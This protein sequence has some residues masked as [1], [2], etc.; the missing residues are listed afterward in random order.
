LQTVKEPAAAPRLRE[1]A[2]KSRGSSDLRLAAAEACG[3]IQTQ[4]LEQDARTLIGNERSG[5]IVDR[6]LAARLLG[7]HRGPEAETLLL[8]LAADP[9]PAVAALAW[10]RLL[11]IDPALVRPLMD[12]A[13]ADRDAN[14]RLLAEQALAAQPTAEHIAR[15]GVM[16]DDPHP[17]N[18]RAVRNLLLKLAD[19]QQF[20]AAV[21]EAAMQALATEKWRALEQAALVVTALDHR[22]AAPRL[23]E[24]LEFERPEVY[25]TA[26]FALRKLA[27]PETLGPALD[28]AQR[29]SEVFL[30]PG[31]PHM[32][33]DEQVSQLFQ[34]FGQ[35]KYAPA[36]PLLR[37]YV[38]KSLEYGNGSR[39]SAVW[40]LGHLHAGRSDSDLVSPL[41]ERL[42]D[43]GSIPSESPY[44]RQMSA[45]SL[46]RMQARAAL[47]V[48]LRYYAMESNY[49]PLG[50]ACQWAIQVQGE[51]PPPPKWRDNPQIGWF[52]TPLE[53]SAESLKQP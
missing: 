44:V 32:A 50:W 42:S 43:T 36:E 16:L 17:E 11:A 25:V 21:G 31:H 14:I 53:D 15:L 6:M 23:V 4:G 38:P 35:M 28:K 45:L 3:A 40:A 29:Q 33:V 18:R 30:A 48:L 52:L 34:M 41:I 39:G 37:K 51:Q 26:A 7:S 27:M 9:E 10:T 49:T 22:P 12:Q 1:L 47:P 8:D 19:D 5:S 13:L 2:L 20:S 24:L 46:G